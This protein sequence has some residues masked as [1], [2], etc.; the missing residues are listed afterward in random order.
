MTKIPRVVYTT[1]AKLQ[2]D[3]VHTTV[4]IL[5]HNEAEKQ[6]GKNAII[7]CKNATIKMYTDDL[8]ADDLLAES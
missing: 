8:L 2:L 4:I 5:S 3:S 6:Y 7:Y 1:V